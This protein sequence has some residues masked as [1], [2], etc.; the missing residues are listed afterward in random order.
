MWTKYFILRRNLIFFTFYSSLAYILQILVSI[1]GFDV[2]LVMSNVYFKGHITLIFY[3]LRPV[4]IYHQCLKIPY[5]LYL[6]TYPPISTHDFLSMW[7]LPCLHPPT[8]CS[9]NRT[10][11]LRDYKTLIYYVM[12]SITKVQFLTINQTSHTCIYTHNITI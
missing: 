5:H 7:R 10:P 11:F 9:V 1:Y 12:L 8:C 6:S 2:Q 3:H 4:D